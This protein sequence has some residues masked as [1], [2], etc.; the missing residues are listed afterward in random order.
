MTHKYN[1]HNVHKTHN[2]K[3]TLTQLH[4]NTALID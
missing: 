2:A 4:K 3:T 1:V